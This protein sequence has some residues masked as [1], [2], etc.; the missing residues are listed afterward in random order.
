MVSKK[1][2]RGVW[3]DVARNA[4]VEELATVCR[5]T[6]SDVLRRLIDLASLGVVTGIR[7]PPANAQEGSG[8]DAA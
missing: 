4:K 8:D 7:M 3:L 5:C 6:R 2:F 1:I